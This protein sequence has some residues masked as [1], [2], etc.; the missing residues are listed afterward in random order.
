MSYSQ[1][2]ETERYQ[3]YSLLKA[4]KLVT[5]IALN[6][7]RH[8][9]TISRELSR[10]KGLR[11]Y[12]PKQA[13]QFATRRRIAHGQ[14]RISDPVWD[15]VERLIKED[16]SPE[17]IGWRL[18]EEQRVCISHE[19]IYQYIYRDK[20]EG[21]EL[22]T[23]LRCQK[24]RRKRYGK[25]DKRGKIVARVG[26]EDRPAI[27][28]TKTRLGD[29]EGD[30]VEGAHHKGY[31]LTLVDRVSKYLVSEPLER[32]TAE[33]TAD[34]T[35]GALSD[36]ILETVTFD[37]GKEFADHER[38]AAE[39][40]TAIYFAD[41]YSSWQRGLNENTNGLLRQYYPKC[42]SLKGLDKKHLAKIVWKLNNKPRKSLGWKTPYEMMYNKKT[43]L[44]SR[45]ALT[46]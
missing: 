30:T 34:A 39:L 2:T 19:W 10:N 16:W 21:G 29:W 11:G 12:Q 22:Y 41:P 43:I 5:E 17:Q 28:E 20:L 45:V 4:G 36:H 46:S 3:I 26:I 23:H 9:S 18:Y 6:L 33:L 8:K 42:K 37:N 44:T 1:L 13:Q 40:E 35:I 31:L 27:V 15:E 32:K 14:V 38:V 24:K 25:Y 7:N